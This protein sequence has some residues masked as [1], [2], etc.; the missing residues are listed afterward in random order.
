MQNSTST[1]SSQSVQLTHELAG[2]AQS[3]AA[4]GRLGDDLQVIVLCEAGSDAFADD[5]M[6]VGQ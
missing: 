3:L 2:F 6:V 1:P 5:G 4:V